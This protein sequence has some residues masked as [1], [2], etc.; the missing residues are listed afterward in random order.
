MYQ[1]H[2]GALALVCT[3]LA[4]TPAP[5]AAQPHIPIPKVAEH[6]E[7]VV[8]VNDKGQVVR[9]VSARGT[10]SKDPIFNAQT[11]GNVLQM[12]IRHPDGSA[13]VG[14]YRVTYDYDPKTK[15]VARRIAIVKRGG[16]WA[17]S[18]GAATQIINDA[19]REAAAAQ[20]HQD[21]E[22][23]RES[24]ALPPLHAIVGPTASPTQKP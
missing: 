24:K 9:A 22:Q 6:A 12:W 4:A 19:K 16:A 21:E 10:G 14:L 17:N 5:K 11:Y 7:F 2:L 1:K 13:E 15:K 20:K 3:L 8:E 18:P 23:K